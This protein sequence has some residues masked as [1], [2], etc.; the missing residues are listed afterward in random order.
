MNLILFY[1]EVWAFVPSYVSDTCNLYFKILNKFATND[2]F[3]FIFTHAKRD[4]TL[5]SQ[6]G[7]MVL[8]VELL[9]PYL[10]LQ[11]SGSYFLDSTKDCWIY[12]S[13]QRERKGLPQIV[14]ASFSLYIT[15]LAHRCSLSALWKT[16]HLFLKIQALAALNLA[17]VCLLL[18]PTLHRYYLPISA[19]TPTSSS[20]RYME[21]F[22]E[23]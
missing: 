9:V 15:V 23:S 11:C 18:S 16:I 5:T 17:S 8:F 20:N 19:E 10:S 12:K 14:W 4:F 22:T 6:S 2:W 13:S 21:D 1:I 7:T 3:G